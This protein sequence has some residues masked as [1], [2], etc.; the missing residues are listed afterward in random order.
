MASVDRSV[1]VGDH[2]IVRFDKQLL[3]YKIKEIT[4]Q[5]IY[6]SPLTGWDLSLL[7]PINGKWQVY[8]FN[9]PHTLEFVEPHIG[10]TEL[11]EVNALILLELPYKDLL[12]ACST[13]REFAQICRSDYFWKQKLAKDFPDL[14][15]NTLDRPRELYTNAYN[16]REREYSKIIEQSTFPLEYD[17]Q[18]KQLIYLI[19]VRHYAADT[20]TPVTIVYRHSYRLLHIRPINYSSAPMVLIKVIRRGTRVSGIEYVILSTDKDQLVV[21]QFSSPE[22]LR[23][24]YEIILPFKVISADLDGHVYEHPLPTFN[25]KILKQIEFNNIFLMKDELP[26]F[27]QNKEI[28]RWY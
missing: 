22:A 25:Q 1:Q 16:Q 14:P 26:P 19:G 5:G 2:V 7:I 13:S 10:L 23:G 6:I 24:P 28:P 15:I 8:G 18:G 20:L 4:N 27:I 17:S 11:P 21:N 3:E 9:I 12:Q